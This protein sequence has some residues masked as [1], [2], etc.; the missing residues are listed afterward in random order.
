MSV[1][2]FDIDVLRS[3]IPLLEHLVPLNNCSQ[4]PLTTATRAAAERYMESWG[5]RGMDWEGWMAEVE[6]CRRAFAAMINAS[7]DEVGVVSSVSHA[8]SAI[9]TALRFDNGRNV[10]V[11]SGAEFP[12]VGHVWLAQEKR[13]ARV[14]WVQV[15]DGAV[16][17]EAYDGAIDERTAI[18]SAAHA[19]YQNG[20]LQDVAAIARRA[21]HQGALTFVDAYQSLGVVPVDV[22]AMGVDMLASG[23]LKYLMGT[24]GIA[25]LYVK[26][27]IIERLEPT[28]TGWFGRVNPFA[29]DATH[30][31]W[32]PHASRFDA[33]TP[34]I[35]AAYVSRAAM[36][37][38]LEIG[39]S[40]IH[41]WT[42]HLSRRLVQGAEARGLTV[43]GPGLA[44][45]KTPSTAIVCPDSHAAEHGLR[46]RGIIG[47][48]RGPAIR[49]APHFY[50]TEADIDRG[51][52]ALAE[53]LRT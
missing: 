42:Q 12:T 53:I 24:P 29:F 13:G 48:A 6:A 43:H 17:L 19:Y 50:N 3:R 21:R 52:D 41:A 7:P 31:D 30:L 20:S 15:A 28:I 35:F 18:V 2:P 10:I 8:T 40:A 1:P 14:R 9:A 49:L 4:A 38:L 46:E 44:A 36:E 34:P 37:W 33:G 16:P 26:G 27:S 23:T 45:P 22:K 39:S 51:L 25:F 47:S 32:S 5:T 11:A